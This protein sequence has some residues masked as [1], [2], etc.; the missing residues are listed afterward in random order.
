MR[1]R[2]APYLAVL[3]GLLV[4]DA[5]EARKVTIRQQGAPEVTITVPAGVRVEERRRV[6]LVG[7]VRVVQCQ[8]ARSD[9]DMTGRAAL[10]REK[11]D[12]PIAGGSC[13]K[14]R[15]ARLAKRLR[16]VLGKGGRTPRTD[17]AAEQLARSARERTLAHPRIVG[18]ASAAPFGHDT[19]VESTFEYDGAYAHQLHRYHGLDLEVIHDTPGDYVRGFSGPDCW[20][21]TSAPE[22]DDALEPRLELDEWDAPPATKTAWHVSYKPIVTLPDRT[23][24]IRWTG[25]VADGE[26]IVGTDGL[27]QRVR[28]DD[29]HMARGRSS[30]QRVDVVFTGF[31]TSPVPRVTPTP[32]C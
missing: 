28:I 4:A 29:H 6:T 7:G 15:D 24:R 32:H 11:A 8:L 26:A 1:H 17:L 23:R 22:D 19:F 14:V 18:T 25:F 10:R 13:L 2:L 21:P 9:R 3:S 27:L 30:W 16:P 20:S 5:A 31:P 12:V